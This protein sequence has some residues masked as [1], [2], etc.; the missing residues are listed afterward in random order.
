M[1]R[2]IRTTAIVAIFSIVCVIIGQSLF[3]TQRQADLQ[4]KIEK[5]LSKEHLRVD[6]ALAEIEGMGSRSAIRGVL[7]EMIS[8]YRDAQPYPAPSARGYFFLGPAVSLLGLLKD[9]KDLQILSDLLADRQVHENVRGRAAQALGEIDAD[10][11][12][13]VL[14]QT[15]D[16]NN[17]AELGVRRFAI[18]ALGKSRDSAVLAALEL[19]IQNEK[20]EYL[21]QLASESIQ[22][23]RSRIQ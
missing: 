9:P 18:E 1:I 2:S 23:I 14:L 11:S 3:A 5:L 6:T 10:A 19:C 4:S 22:E 8:K 13:E 15:L 12:K 17:P 21:R 20:S 7:R 16:P